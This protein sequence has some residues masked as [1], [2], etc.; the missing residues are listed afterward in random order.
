MIMQLGWRSIWRNHRRTAVILMAIVVGGWSMIVS[1]SVMR[2]VAR[3]MLEDGVSTMTGHLQVHRGGYRL[4]PSARRGIPDPRRVEAALDASLPPGAR[5][6]TRVR[7]A[8]I[9]S[10]A[11]RSA[12]LTL[13][14][15]DPQ[16]EAGGL[17]H[18]DLRDRGAVSSA[19]ATTATSWRDGRC[20]TS[21]A[22]ASGTSW[23]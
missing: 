13:V 18:P 19:P 21:S 5:R 4:D 22:P 20:W 17:V 11:R 16:A 3:Q 7:V 23:C 1:A 9:V 15:I 10:N 6:A 14:G 12:G 8:G 2:G